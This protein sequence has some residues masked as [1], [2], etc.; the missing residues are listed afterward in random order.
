[1][2]LYSDTFQNIL[3]LRVWLVIN[4]WWFY[5]LVPIVA[6]F[7]GSRH[8][9]IGRY[10]RCTL[11]CLLGFLFAHIQFM[12]WWSQINAAV[13]TDIDKKWLADHDGGAL[14]LVPFLNALFSL[15]GWIVCIFLLFI[16]RIRPV[17]GPNVFWAVQEHKTS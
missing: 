1:M 12:W 11:A 5:L 9:G 16:C 2:P 15:S 17:S 8:Q 14:T 10:G 7:W 6:L 13:S 3:D 4:R